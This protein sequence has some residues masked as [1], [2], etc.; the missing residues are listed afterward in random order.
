[1]PDV[2]RGVAII[3]M[4]LAHAMLFFP[5]AS[6][7]MVFVVANVNDLASPLFALVM[8]MSA[9]IVWDRAPRWWPTLGQQWLRG[10]AL[11][12]LGLWMATWGSWVVIILAYL[13]LLLIVGV[14]LLKLRTGWLVMATIFAVIVSAPL[15]AWARGLASTS[16]EWHWATQQLATWAALG[17]SYRLTNLLPFFLFGALL[18]RH[19]FRRDRWLQWMLV[20]A[21]ITYLVRPLGERMLG[22]PEVSGS[23]PDTL[24]DVGLVFA[25]YVA[26]VWLATVTRPRPRRVIDGLFVPIRACGEVALS[27]Y[28]L[29]V[30]IIAVWAGS[31]GL[32]VD[33]ILL[34]WVLTVPLVVLVGWAWWR[35]VG[36]GPV[37]WLL[38]WVTGRPKRPRASRGAA[39]AGPHR[40]R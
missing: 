26:V 29:H 22:W 17:T 35:F 30:G 12:V 23:Y 21:P 14:P 4:L 11:I 13:G 9:Q 33:T 39:S 19:G 5:D 32:P 36:T 37:E 24:H 8:G 25:T 31:L 38:G 40:Q 1:M 10:L 7:S 28:L 2:L 16:P 34:G 18:L 6:A 20:A 3:A 27:L 15:N